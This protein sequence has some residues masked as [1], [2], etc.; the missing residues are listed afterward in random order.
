MLTEAERRVIAYLTREDTPLYAL[1]ELADRLGAFGAFLDTHR[2]F[3]TD[4]GLPPRPFG[5]SPWLYRKLGRLYDT[6]ATGSSAPLA[7]LFPNCPQPDPPY[8]WVRVS[9]LPPDQ[10]YHLGYYQQCDYHEAAC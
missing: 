4:T 5:D 7:E 2:A 10:D 9:P 8:Q 6:R 1:Y 3:L